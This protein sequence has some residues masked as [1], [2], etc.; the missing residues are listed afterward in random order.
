MFKLIRL[1]E[2]VV[3]DQDVILT[4]A[5]WLELSKPCRTPSSFN[6]VY[7]QGS[8]WETAVANIAIEC[9]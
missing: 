6:L 5:L 1:F 4:S 8:D 2:F 3:S 9:M 7:H